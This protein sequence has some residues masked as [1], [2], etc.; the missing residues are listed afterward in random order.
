VVRK[1]PLKVWREMIREPALLRL[2][3]LVALIVGVRAVYT[4]LYILMPSTGCARSG[5]TRR[6]GP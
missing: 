2:A 3:V 4:Y 5:R 6:S 1:N